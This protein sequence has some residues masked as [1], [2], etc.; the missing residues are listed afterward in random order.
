MLGNQD[1][2]VEKSEV[3]M[4]IQSYLFLLIEYICHFPFEKC[5]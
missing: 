1:K 4:R 3:C 2:M 5:D